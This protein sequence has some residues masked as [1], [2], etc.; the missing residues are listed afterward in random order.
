MRLPVARD[1]DH[2]AE[3]RRQVDLVLLQRLDL[4]VG[5]LAQVCA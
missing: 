2:F 1:L 3:Q 4:Q 5:Q